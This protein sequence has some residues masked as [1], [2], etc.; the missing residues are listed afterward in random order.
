M[1]TL[2]SVLIFVIF[3][4][5]L[6]NKWTGRRR[7]DIDF[8]IDFTRKDPTWKSASPSERKILYRFKMETI[9]NP[10][11]LELLREAELEAIQPGYKSEHPYFV[12]KQ[13]KKKGI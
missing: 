11:L 4:F 9:A 1:E 5:I 3:V 8:A 12:A 10:E 13:K 7:K 6:F 2:V